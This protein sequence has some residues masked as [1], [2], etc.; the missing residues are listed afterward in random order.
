MIMNRRITT[1]AAA[2]AVVA[3]FGGSRLGA[4]TTTGSFQTGT[5]DSDVTPERT[6]DPEY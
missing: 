6:R 2:V 1:L 4:Q 5:G 3:S